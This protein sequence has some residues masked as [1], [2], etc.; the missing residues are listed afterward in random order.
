M[1]GRVRSY[2]TSIKEECNGHVSG[3]KDDTFLNFVPF[4]F[5]AITFFLQLVLTIVTSIGKKEFLIVRSS[6]PIDSLE[7]DKPNFEC[8]EIVEK[9]FP[10]KEPNLIG[11]YKGF[12]A[13]LEIDG[14]FPHHVAFSH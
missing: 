12:L 8:L 5:L 4:F 1:E 14:N 7:Y 2:S 3:E 9:F 6:K 10:W 11:G 13:R